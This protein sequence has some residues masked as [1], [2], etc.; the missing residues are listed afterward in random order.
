MG[1]VPRRSVRRRIS[2]GVLLAVV[3]SPGSCATVSKHFVLEPEEFACESD[4]D[5][6]IVAA[7]ITGAGCC[8]GTPEEPYAISKATVRRQYA[9]NRA[10]CAAH[11]PCTAIMHTCCCTKSS[12]WVAV[13]ARHVCQ[14]SSVSFF[15]P[16]PSCRP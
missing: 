13:C 11:A 9:I 16:T 1:A 4:T 7:D 6:Q 3:A 10:R 12:D 8:G 2:L 15:S 14:R 5:C